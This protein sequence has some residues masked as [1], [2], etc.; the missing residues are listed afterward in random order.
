MD[1]NGL[2]VYPTTINSNVTI[3][4]LRFPK[5]PQWTYNIV[6]NEPFFNPNSATYKDFELP[7]D[8]FANLVIKILSYA[9]VSIR[10]QDIVQAAK[11]EEIQDI[12]QKQ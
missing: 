4:Y 12:Q 7:L 2:L 3:Q 10:E 9:G 5:D 1:E 11:S 8:D 6:N